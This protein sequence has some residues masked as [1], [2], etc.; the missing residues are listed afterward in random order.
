MSRHE[1]R[2]VTTLPWLRIEAAF[3][4]IGLLCTTAEAER[5]FILVQVQDAQR[6]PVRGIEIGIDGYGGSKVTGDDGKAK[7]PLGNQ[8]KDGDW[9]TLSILHSPFGEV[10]CNIRL[11]TTVLSYPPLRIRP[12]IL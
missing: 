9:V 5:G 10:S 11:G 6:H 2:W 3:L 12:K 4:F 7:I 1:R 8:T